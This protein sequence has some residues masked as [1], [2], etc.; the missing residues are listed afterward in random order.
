MVP[1]HKLGARANRRSVAT[2][3][4]VSGIV[5]AL[6]VPWG[7]LN[8]PGARVRLLPDI[9]A[10]GEVWDWTAQCPSG[11]SGPSTPG[12]CAT[13]DPNI[14]LAQLDGDEWNLGGGQATAGSV[15]M[16][17]GSP[18]TLAVR[19]DLP[20]A[21]P[22]TEP[23]CLAPSANTWVRGYPNVL[24][25]MSQCHASTSPP[26]SPHLRLPM[27]V[28]AIPSD[29]IGTTAYSSQAQQVTYDIAYDMWLNPTGTRAPCHT[30]GTVEVMV[31]TD[32]DARA[33]LPGSM[34]MGTASVPFAVDG[35]E[36]S[37]TAD[38]SVY[39]TN[40]YPGGQTAPWGGTIWFVLDQA[41]VISK[42]TVS[43][44]LSRVL[45]SAG[46]LLTDHYDWGSFVKGYWLDTVPFG[47]EFGPQSGTL[48]GAGPSYF[49]LDI[50]SYC[51]NVAVKV[52]KATC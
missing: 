12:A 44:D 42:G 39:A 14:G 4:V 21:P 37:G 3:M 34:Q 13:S 10:K 9:A 49:S 36:N 22:C 31:W 2:I 41:N 17:L 24:Y 35:V 5:A 23:T 1:R 11:P 40:I 43:V 16:S 32:Y 15:R 33:L 25:G 8:G 52:A 47:I 20:S 6:V 29:L 19:G 26:E 38:W 18:G 48:A 27:V 45:S 51:L 28:S 46:A 50:S 30:A 7:D